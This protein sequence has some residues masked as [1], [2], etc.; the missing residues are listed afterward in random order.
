MS[1]DISNSQGEKKVD[2][3]LF[4]NLNNFLRL[5]LQQGIRV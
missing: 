3:E 2:I 4:I 1:N 5:S